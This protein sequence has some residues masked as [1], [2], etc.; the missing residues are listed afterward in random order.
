MLSPAPPCALSRPLLPPVS[1]VRQ[2]KGPCHRGNSCLPPQELLPFAAALSPGTSGEANRL[3]R[4][5]GSPFP[6]VSR[7]SP[8]ALPDAE[9]KLPLYT[10]VDLGSKQAALSRLEQCLP[11]V[12]EIHSVHGTAHRDRTRIWSFPFPGSV[13]ALPAGLSHAL[14]SAAQS[15]AILLHSR[16]PHA[17]LEPLNHASPSSGVS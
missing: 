6:L 5:S 9:G 3:L 1:G 7:E 8:P 15:R 14:R 11:T 4:P 10:S 16:G 2:A 12:P 17:A 13:S